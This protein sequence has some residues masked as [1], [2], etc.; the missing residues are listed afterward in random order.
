MKN[1]PYFQPKKRSYMER[2][3]DTIGQ[4]RRFLIVC[5]G[6]KTEPNYFNEFRVYR[7]RVEVVGTGYNTMKVAEA[8]IRLKL[9]APKTDPYIKVWVVF[10]RDDFPIE[11]FN[12]AIQ[13]AIQNQIEVAYSNQAFELWYLLHFRYLNTSITRL[14]YIDRLSQCLGHEYKKKSRLIY[15]ELLDR[16][17]NAI[18]NAQKLLASYPNSSSI[19]H[20]DPSTKVHLLVQELNRL[21]K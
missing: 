4:K 21:S 5:E 11:N 14:D 16:Q 20:N 17:S 8:A 9:K 12:R 1:S 15:S 3:V 19:Y 18:L 10:D 7:L 6:E 13:L 2:P